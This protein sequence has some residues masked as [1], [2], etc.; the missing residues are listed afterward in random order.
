MSPL[1]KF[2]KEDYE[3]SYIG[4]KEPWELNDKNNC[5][6]FRKISDRNE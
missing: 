2:H 3:S 4:E 6:L 1:N 5:K